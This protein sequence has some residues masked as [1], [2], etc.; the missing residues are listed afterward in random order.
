[1]SADVVEL[2]QPA[3]LSTLTKLL[4]TCHDIGGIYS[5]TYSEAVLLTDDYSKAQ[6]GG[7]PQGGWLLAAAIDGDLTNPKSWVLQDE[8]IILLRVREVTPLPHE[9]DLVSGRMAVVADAHASGIGYSDVAD[10]HTRAQQGQSAFLADVVGVFYTDDEHKRAEFGAELDNVWASATYRVFQPSAKALSWIASY[11]RKRDALHLG[12]VRFSATTRAAKAHGLDQAAVQVNVTDFVGKKTA[13]LGMT[14][15]GKSNTIKTLVTAVYQHAAHRNQRIGQIIFDPQGEYAKV[16]AQDGTGLRLLGDD[17]QVRIYTA[18]PSAGE[19]Q[20]HP[21]RLNFYDT[22]LFE[23]AWDMVVG[24][25]EG[26]EANYVRTFRSADMERPD[27][28]DFR[29]QT[30]WGRGYMAFYGLLYRAGYKGQFHNGATISFSMKDEAAAKFNAEHQG[31]NL[32]GG[33]GVYTVSSPEQAALVVDW[34]NKLLGRMDKMAKSTKEEDAEEVEEINDLVG[35]WL[36]SDQFTAVADVFKYAKG[37]G[38]AGLRELREF[39]DPSGR[40]DVNEMVWQDMVEGR[41]VIVDLSIGSDTV[42]KAMSERLIDALVNKASER[43][44]AGN[45]PVPFQVVVE[46][47][48]NL[49]ERGRDARNDPWVRMSKEA[50]KYEIGLVYATQEVTSVD[51]RIL[52]NTHNWVVAHLNSDIEIRELARYYDFATFGASIKR[53]EERGFVRLKTLS[54]P[55][56]VPTQ[57][58]KFDHSMINNARVAAGLAPIHRTDESPDP[59]PAGRATTDPGTERG[60]ER[61][62]AAARLGDGEF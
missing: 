48:H 14:R 24:A 26:A 11:P 54:S 18:A 34:V 39:H 12:V 20:E 57:V 6:Y 40:G 10:P 52:S 5:L 62:A 15:A 31:M 49:F 3:D 50:A 53:A 36:E 56:I 33:S 38:L 29:A 32:T 9:R 8:E 45:R 47:A 61:V 30:H 28:N 58:R 43:F 42:T 7:I 19:P 60:Q 35:K 51:Q 37:R 22:D 55:F 46:E 17:Q 59:A 25:M 44:R 21:L 16:N 4:R 23:V 13:V 27:P 2:A 41:L 1:M